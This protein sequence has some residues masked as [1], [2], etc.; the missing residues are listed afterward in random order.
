MVDTFL[1]KEKF[2]E[3]KKIVEETM[4]KL[5]LLGSTEATEQLSKVEMI[6]EKVKER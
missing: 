6:M 1:A 3:S 4:T 2:E 5:Y